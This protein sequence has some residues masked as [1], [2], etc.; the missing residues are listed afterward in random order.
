MRQLFY[1]FIILILCGFSII[2]P[3][4]TI[5]KVEG[6]E[7]YF[8]IIQNSNFKD[9]PNIQFSND[10]IISTLYLN[11]D[12]ISFAFDESS[13]KIEA[14]EEASPYFE[15]YG[16][17]FKMS[18]KKLKG[19]NIGSEEIMIS[20][21]EDKEAKKRRKQNKDNFDFS[22]IIS[23]T[24]LKTRKINAENGKS[25]VIVVADINRGIRSFYPSQLST[26]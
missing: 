17:S 12:K 8:K 18:I 7:K 13:I 20:L 3:R 5:W 25:S 6:S 15:K 4:D 9:C 1:L 23:F 14:V 10:T 22:D 26:K 24:I 2:V 11:T 16:F 21:K 19:K